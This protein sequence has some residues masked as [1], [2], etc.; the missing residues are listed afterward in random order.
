MSRSGNSE[1]LVE[2]AEESVMQITKDWE[3]ICYLD[4]ER[5]FIALFHNVVTKY[6]ILLLF[7]LMLTLYRSSRSSNTSKY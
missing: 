6:S 4:V 1:S 5:L 3:K 2:Y 7:L